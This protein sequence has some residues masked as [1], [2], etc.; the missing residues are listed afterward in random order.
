M[1]G[2]YSVLNASSASYDNMV[3]SLQRVT[4]RGP[5]NTS[6]QYIDNLHTFL[7]FH[8][9]SINGLDP[10]SNQ[11]MYNASKDIVLLCNGQI[12]NHTELFHCFDFQRENKSDCEIIL[13]LY[14]RFGIEYTLTLLDGVFAFILMDFRDTPICYVSRDPLGVRPLFI[15]YNGN[16][17]HIGSEIKTLQSCNTV[18]P[19]QPGAWYTF[20]YEREVWKNTTHK[21]YFTLPITSFT[22]ASSIKDVFNTSM[23]FPHRCSMHPKLKY[24]IPLFI[25]SKCFWFKNRG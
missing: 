12:Y 21:T 17:I 14:E 19:V 3:C 18:K 11:P 6:V 2:I 5:D 7:G 16:E 25:V 20:Q 8:R 1:C 23:T 24:R 10:E 15:G 9:L 13:H 22:N 4:H